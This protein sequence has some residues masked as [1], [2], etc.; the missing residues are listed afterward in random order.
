MARGSPAWRARGRCAASE[1]VQKRERAPDR[2]RGCGARPRVAGHRAT[3]LPQT[4]ARPSAGRPAPRLPRAAMPA[5]RVANR[6]AAAQLCPGACAATNFHAVEAA[7][8]AAVDAGAATLFLPECFSFVGTC[9]AD[10]RAAATPADGPGSAL[11]PYR[12]LARAT[13]LWIFAGGFPESGGGAGGDGQDRVFNAHV[14]LDPRGATAAAYRKVHLFDAEGLTESASTAPGDRLAVAVAPCGAV[15]LTVCYDVRF[16]ALAQSLR[17]DMGARV[18][19]IPAAF[20]RATGEAHWEVLLRARAIETQCAV[21]AAAAAGVHNARRA[22]HGHT[23]IIDA[24]GRVLAR[25][26]GDGPGLAVADLGDAEVEAVRARMPLA[27]H[28]AAGRRA[29][30]WAATEGGG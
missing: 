21:V 7:A 13:G 24:W 25:V 30:G 28:R 22:S 20:T 18:L 19:A 6:V 9:A 26:E 14:A 12:D 11:A 3:S 4:R 23:M 5:P 10:T 15:G 16:P 27:A 8:A 1:T 29:L 2:A 17:F